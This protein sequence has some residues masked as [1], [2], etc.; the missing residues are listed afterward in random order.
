MARRTKAQKR[1]SALK[2]WETRRATAETARRSAAARRGARKSRVKAAFAPGVTHTRREQI[3]A[4]MSRQGGT[5]PLD[6][7]RTRFSEEPS[8]GAPYEAWQ[9]V[10]RAFGVTIRRASDFSRV[11]ES[12]GKRF[13]TTRHRIHVAGVSRDRG[14]GDALHRSVEQA[15]EHSGGVQNRAIT[16]ASVSLVVIPTAASG[17]RRSVLPATTVVESIDGNIHGAL[18]HTAMDSISEAQYTAYSGSDGSGNIG[19]VEYLEIEVN[20][21]ELEV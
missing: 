2:G 13:Y 20:Y 1:A 8:H 15:R 11:L 7:L 17:K 5:L 3:F 4:L 12:S 19:D 9:R 6:T 21:Y 10:E 16:A 18:M 14:I